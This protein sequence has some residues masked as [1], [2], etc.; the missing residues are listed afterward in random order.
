MSDQPGLREQADAIWEQRITAT[1]DE[2]EF[3]LAVYLML[4]ILV[5]DG[6]ARATIYGR[7]AARISILRSYLSGRIPSNRLRRST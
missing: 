1:Q 2:L 6:I 7:R 5:S 3:A 4:P